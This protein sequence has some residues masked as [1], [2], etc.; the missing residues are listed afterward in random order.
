MI[1]LDTH[2]WVW[3]VS[4]SDALS[5]KARRLLDETVETEPVYV[6]SISV[7]EVSLLARRGRLRLTIP[8]TDWIAKSEALPFLR[9]VPVDNRIAV[10]SVLLPEPLHGDPADRIIVATTLQLSGR[11]ITKDKKLRAYEHIDTVW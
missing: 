6:S 2:A 11:L 1:V 7:W 4:R 3:W 9:F 10:R 5:R 8:L